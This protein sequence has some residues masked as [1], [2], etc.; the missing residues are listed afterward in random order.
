MTMLSRLLQLLQRALTSDRIGDGEGDELLAE[1][2]YETGTRA[3]LTPD[4]L[5]SAGLL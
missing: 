2:T 3:V 1:P 4:V 5:R